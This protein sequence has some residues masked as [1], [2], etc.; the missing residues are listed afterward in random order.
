MLGWLRTDICG[1]VWPFK[2]LEYLPERFCPAGLRRLRDRV[3]QG[4]SPELIRAYPSFGLSYS[5][6]PVNVSRSRHWIDG[7]REFCRLVLSEGIQHVDGVYGFTAAAL[8]MLVA[9]RNQGKTAVLD[10]IMAPRAVE[11]QLLSQEQLAYSG[12]GGEEEEE[13]NERLRRRG[14]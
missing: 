9:A 6:R 4:I 12:W 14:V 13:Y 3:P 8:E 7:G 10:Q 5:R 1:S 2:M 11:H